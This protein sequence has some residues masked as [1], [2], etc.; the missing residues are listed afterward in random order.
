M[1]FWRE[2]PYT[3]YKFS[4]QSVY[5][6]PTA[7]SQ[8]CTLLFKRKMIVSHKNSKGVSSLS[9]ISLFFFL[10]IY[11]HHHTHHFLYFFLSLSFSLIPLYTIL[12]P[13]TILQPQ[14]QKRILLKTN[15]RQP[16]KFKRCFL[17]VL[18]VSHIFF[19]DIYHHHHS[20]SSNIGVVFPK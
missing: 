6:S 15:D 10:D 16:Q 5:Y 19:L 3:K 13:Y 2:K 4:P 18:S 1:F 14:S 8:K 9:V 7:Q 12:K 17:V 20:N 11:H